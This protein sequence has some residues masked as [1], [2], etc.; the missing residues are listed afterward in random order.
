MIQRSR[1]VFCPPTH[2]HAYPHTCT[3][4]HTC[5]HL[6]AGL[7]ARLQCAAHLLEVCMHSED[8]WLGRQGN[9]CFAKCLCHAGVGRGGDFDDE[10][11]GDLTVDFDFDLF[12]WTTM[13]N[14]YVLYHI[15]DDS[16][17]IAAFSLSLLPSFP[18]PISESQ[19]RLGDDRDTGKEVVFII[20]IHYTYELLFIMSD[21]LKSLQYSVCTHN[22][23]IM[24]WPS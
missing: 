2:P 3:H 15:S 20:H 21:D 11:G 8:L 7:D 13:F 19:T 22:S 4:M 24:A 14:M 16:R 1:C 12:C 5:T 17:Y 6:L 18:L 23:M 10:C 9:C